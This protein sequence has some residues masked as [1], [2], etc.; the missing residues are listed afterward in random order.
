M[1]IVEPWRRNNSDEELRAVRV[2]PGIGHGH[3]VRPVVFQLRMKLVGEILR[4]DRLPAGAVAE[5][6]ALNENE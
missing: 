3:G 2:G 5:R 1:F 4:P 6:I